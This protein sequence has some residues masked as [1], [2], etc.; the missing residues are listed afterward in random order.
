M[1]RKKGKKLTIQ[2][3]YG[4]LN[5]DKIVIEVMALV[6]VTVWMM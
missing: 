2:R 5:L 4:L 3:I 1:S 6:F